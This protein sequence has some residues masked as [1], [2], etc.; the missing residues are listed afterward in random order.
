MKILEQDLPL[1]IIEKRLHWL[2]LKK[3]E[4]FG[5]ADVQLDSFQLVEYYY[6]G[7]YYT[8][9]Q[10]NVIATLQGTIYP[11]SL[12]IIGGHHDC[13]VK[14]SIGNPFNFAPGANDN[15]SGVATTL[16]VA[17][18]L[19]RVDFQPKTTIKFVTFA[20]EELGLHGSSDYA[21]KVFQTNSKIKMML[22]NDMVAY[23]PNSDTSNWCVNIIDY[24]N[25]TSLRKKAQDVCKIYTYL[26]TN[27]D[28]T[29]QEY[30]DSYPFSLKGYK[31]IFFISNAND[32]NY[33][34]PN[35]LTSK[36]NFKFCKEVAKIN[37]VLL[38]ENNFAD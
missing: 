15:A 25:S 33:H 27:N 12:S 8:N 9:W 36:C 28:N 14:S 6:N 16:E 29:Y 37:C 21:E 19:K 4:S 2:F 20:A 31:A 30:S 11:D 17:R 18:V 32:V 24:T 10:Y 22:N 38:V 23:W 34:T 3:F 26:K 5:Y 35:D 13:I 7:N 1:Q